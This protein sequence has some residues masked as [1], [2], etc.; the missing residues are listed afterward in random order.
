MNQLNDYDKRNSIPEQ[1][2]LPIMNHAMA[3]YKG[4]I[5]YGIITMILY[6]LGCYL[7]QNIIGF[8]SVEMVDQLRN[9]DGDY[10]EFNYM[11]TPGFTTYLGLSGLFGILLSPLFVG[12]IYILDLYNRGQQVRFADLFTGY[13][14]NVI[15]IMVYS[16]ILGIISTVAM[17]FCIVPFFFVY[18][19]LLL[20]YPILLFENASATEALAKSVSTAKQNY[21]TFLAVTFLGLLLSGIGAALCGIGFVATAP[22]IFVIMYSTY[23]AFRGKPDAVADKKEF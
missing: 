15:N 9:S 1:H 3:M 6:L 2:T 5:L 23:C 13:K 4:V 11:N 17:F 18:P 7:I 20:G 12:L 8:D 14:N 19:L 16:I 10:S 22:F 21:G